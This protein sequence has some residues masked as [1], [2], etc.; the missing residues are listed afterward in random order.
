MFGGCFIKFFNEGL[1]FTKSCLLMLML[2]PAFD[3][4]FRVG[5]DG[6]CVDRVLS[7]E[8]GGIKGGHQLF[9]GIGEFTEF[10]HRDVD[11]VH[12]EV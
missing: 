5:G 8:C 11:T 10:R 3:Q 7:L 2:L 9:G 12:G 4:K 1:L 6:L